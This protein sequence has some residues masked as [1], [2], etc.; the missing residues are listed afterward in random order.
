MF[1]SIANRPN[2]HQPMEKLVA[3]PRPSA[4]SPDSSLGSPPVPLQPRRASPLT[5]SWAAF[6][7]CVTAP[8]PRHV[9]LASSIPPS[10]TFQICSTQLMPLFL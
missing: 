9:G 4:H 2:P 6:L 3:P 10:P 5:A 1:P 7:S 8:V